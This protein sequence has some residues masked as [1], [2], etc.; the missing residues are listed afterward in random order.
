MS[1]NSQCYLPGRIDSLLIP[2]LPRRTSELTDAK[3]EYGL[4]P[5]EHWV[6]PDWIDEE[7]AKAGRDKLSEEHVI[8]ADSVSYVPHTTMSFKGSPA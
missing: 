8:Y 6:Q 3:V 5:G 4:I 7:R 1:S 2:P